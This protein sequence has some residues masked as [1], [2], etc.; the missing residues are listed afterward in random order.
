[1]MRV[2][3][4]VDFNR[5]EFVRVVDFKIEAPVVQTEVPRG[6]ERR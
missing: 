4:F 5:L 1:M 6:R 3:P 2:L